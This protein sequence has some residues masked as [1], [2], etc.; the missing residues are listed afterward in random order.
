MR[1]SRQDFRDDKRIMTG[2]HYKCSCLQKFQ[3]LEL[4]TSV[5]YECVDLHPSTSPVTGDLVRRNLFEQSDYL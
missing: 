5:S 1:L 2:S 4:K 3:S